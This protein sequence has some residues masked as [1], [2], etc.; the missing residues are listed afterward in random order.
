VSSPSRGF[1][2]LGDKTCA[3]DHVCFAAY[4]GGSDRNVAKLKRRIP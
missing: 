4:A 3:C 2:A 1:V